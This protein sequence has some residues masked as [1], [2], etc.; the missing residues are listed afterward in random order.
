MKLVF[1]PSMPPPLSTTHPAANRACHSNC[2][3]V[4]SNREPLADLWTGL[5]GVPKIGSYKS[6]VRTPVH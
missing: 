1:K 2:N 3:R 4:I 6:E 5:L